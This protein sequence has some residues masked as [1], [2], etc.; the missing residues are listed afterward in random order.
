[1]AVPC[2]FDA[3]ENPGAAPENR[4]TPESPIAGS[5]FKAGA[6]S[7][8]AGFVSICFNLLHRLII[9]CELQSTK[10]IK[11]Y[12][13]NACDANSSSNLAMLVQESN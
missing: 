2:I 1:M 12:N 3:G 13:P 4:F 6:R 11:M 5:P 7:M 8:Q 10:C 9:T